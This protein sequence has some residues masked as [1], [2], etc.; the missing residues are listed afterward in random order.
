MCTKVVDGFLIINI[1]ALAPRSHE[2]S[3]SKFEPLRSTST[4]RK[5]W[6]CVIERDKRIIF[7]AKLGL[8]RTY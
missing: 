8:F 1:V 3:N 7:S 6:E 2:S 5:F 4:P